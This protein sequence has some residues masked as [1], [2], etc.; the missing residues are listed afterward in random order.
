[1]RKTL[2]LVCLI[3]ALALAGSAHGQTPRLH[4]ISLP[5]PEREI[6]GRF[7]LRVSEDPF[8][9]PSGSSIVIRLDNQLLAECSRTPCDLAWETE[10]I[11][12]G[13]HLIQLVLLEERGRETTE[14]ILDERTITIRNH[15]PSKR[16]RTEEK[17]RV[18]EPDRVSSTPQ[19]PPRQK[20][21]SFSATDTRRAQQPQ[22]LEL[23]KKSSRDSETPDVRR[24]PLQ[25]QKVELRDLNATSLLAVGRKLYV[26]LANGGVTVYDTVQGTGTTIAGPT[27]AGETRELAAADGAIWWLTAPSAAPAAIGKPAGGLQVAAVMGAQLC[28][29]RESDG[30]LTTQDISRH[31]M[32]GIR[33][34]PRQLFVWS[35]RV[36]LF[37]GSAAT[38]FDTKTERY[39]D[40]D[41]LLPAEA[42]RAR[43]RGAA[44]RFA[45]DG[46]GATVATVENGDA[47]ADGGGTQAARIWQSRGRDWTGGEARN[48]PYSSAA[49]LGITLTT[50]I[51]SLVS[52]RSVTTIRLTGDAEPRSVS[53][54]SGLPA[55]DGRTQLAASGSDASNIW[56]LRGGVLFH[57]D[58]KN[59]TAD[60]LFPWNE[61]GLLPRALAADKGMVWIASSKGVRRISL[62]G[63]E[64]VNG[65]S[66]PAVSGGSEGYGG[67]IR[68][69]LGEETMTTV[70]FNEQKLAAAIESWQ[71]T[72][73]LWGGGSR[74]GVDCS[75]FVM[76]AYREAGIDLPHGSDNLRGCEMGER[77]T[78]E[79]RYGDVLIYPGHAAIYIG[80]G[81]TAETVSSGKRGVGKS[82]VWHR[83]EV[84]V[85]RFFNVADQPKTLASRGGR[86]SVRKTV[87]TSTKSAAKK[88]TITRR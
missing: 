58:T 16:P 79:L 53:L 66:G 10:G 39:F 73:Y 56:W 11:A 88:R 36:V 20:A 72:P 7:T 60:A 40:L 57:A 41:E 29:Y 34:E 78:D 14:R 87:K 45:S 49:N 19:A 22:P 32:S 62:A 35:G 3:L 13:R 76:V 65:S 67:F 24:T 28:C 2:P 85:R 54:P 33:S 59:E 64:G 81:Q 61:K 9:R 27:G 46:S 17:K 30:A 55:I 71:G 77:I 47:P 51:L 70:G 1:M 5:S 86:P 83:S 52:P 63:R 8:T 68:A 26:G 23:E 84:V 4:F 12:D 44:L 80:N 38:V 50:T 21:G 6:T 42:L 82:T 43:R 75:G 15:V 31:A 25:A 37:S 48:I 18:E 74:K 69:R